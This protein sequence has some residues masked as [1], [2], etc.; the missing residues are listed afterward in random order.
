[1]KNVLVE[2]SL[3]RDT[4]VIGRDTAVIGTR[5]SC[6][7]HETKPRASGGGFHYHIH[8]YNWYKP[9]TWFKYTPTPKK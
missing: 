6:H 1:M 3:A 9:H 7:W 4:A 2:V 5:Q 8:K